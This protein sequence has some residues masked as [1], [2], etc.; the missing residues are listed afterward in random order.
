MSQGRW[1]YEEALPGIASSMACSTGSASDQAGL[2]DALLADAMSQDIVGMPGLPADLSS[3]PGVLSHEGIP[4]TLDSLQ[5]EA[6]A[7]AE[8]AWPVEAASR[9]GSS[10]ES[11]VAHYLQR[12]RE[13]RR[14]AIGRS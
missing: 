7:A 14:T 12:G 8:E 5:L 2:L 3:V 13:A 6:E 4:A 11:L 1:A 10:R 9:P